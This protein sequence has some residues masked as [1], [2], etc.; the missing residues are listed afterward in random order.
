MRRSDR[1]WLLSP[2]LT[3]DGAEE[4]IDLVDNDK[5]VRLITRLNDRDILSGV[6]DPDAIA[7]I[8]DAGAKVR[9]HNYRLHAKLWVFEDQAIT[10]SANLTKQ[11]LSENIEL[12]VIHQGSSSSLL[13]DDFSNLWQR[14]RHNTKTSDE[15]RAIAER[16]RNNPTRR[17]F[18]QVAAHNGLIDY[19]GSGVSNESSPQVGSG[20]WLKINGLRSDRIDMNEDLREDYQFEGGQTFPG[21]K[22]RPRGLREGDLVILSRIGDKNGR[23]DRCIYGRGIVD[24]AHRQGI[25]EVPSWLRRVMGASE[26]REYQVDRWP[27]IVWLRD[28]QLVDGTAADCPWLSDLNQEQLIVGQKSHLA[29]TE[30]QAMILERALEQ[31]FDTVG[32]IQL[33]RPEG[34]WW[35][36]RI[37]DPN[38]YVTRT[39]L[40]SHP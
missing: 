40:E 36:S 17:R 38:Q 14:L 6:L 32:C 21:P 30:E 15:L 7:N 4:F 23:P 16:L 20:F 25:D 22:Q 35:N 1:I 26:Y 39:R 12:M 9:F 28:V 31:V 34:I 27:N 3:S 24:V 18:Q 33:E 5:D 10:G 8:Q 37:S 13:A 29:I 19:G 2:Y 11:A